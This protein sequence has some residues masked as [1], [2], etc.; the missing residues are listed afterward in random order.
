MK[1]PLIPLIGLCLLSVPF[2]PEAQSQNIQ[3]F[4]QMQQDTEHQL[5]EYATPRD[6]PMLPQIQLHGN[7]FTTIQKPFPDSPLSPQY[8]LNP[9]TGNYQRIM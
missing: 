9:H 8:I 4:D 3:Y 1:H 6:P 5:R 7:P 2:L